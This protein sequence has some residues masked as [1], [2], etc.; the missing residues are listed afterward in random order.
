LADIITNYK[1]RKQVK[2]CLKKS[3]PLQRVPET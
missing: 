2:P 1:R 3:V